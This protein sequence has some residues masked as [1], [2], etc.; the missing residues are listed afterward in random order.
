MNY[1]RT[2]ITNAHKNTHTK[3]R[4]NCEIKRE[5]ARGGGGGVCISREKTKGVLLPSLHV[6]GEEGE[7]GGEEGK[8]TRREGRQ[9]RER[10]EERRREKSDTCKAGSGRELRGLRRRACE[11]S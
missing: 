3:K 5:A 4:V 2:A 11:R 9:R 1:P 10:K 6:R 7:E 8:G